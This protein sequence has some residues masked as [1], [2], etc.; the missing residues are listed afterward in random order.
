[1]PEYRMKVAPDNVAY[2]DAEN[3][4]LIGSSPSQERQRIPLISRCWRTASTC[5][6]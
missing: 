1:M 4:K 6:R 2:A 5:Q 3:R